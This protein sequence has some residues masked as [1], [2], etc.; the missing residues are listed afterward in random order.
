[1]QG[2]VVE[3]K[4]LLLIGNVLLAPAIVLPIAILK[5]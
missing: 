3:S 2:N 5:Q 4:S 1:M